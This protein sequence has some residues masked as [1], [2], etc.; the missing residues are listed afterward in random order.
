[1]R[2][3]AGWSVADETEVTGAEQEDEN[4]LLLARAFEVQ[5]KKCNFF[6][7]EVFFSCPS[8]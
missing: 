3:S 8:L 7:G 2:I 1:V 5:E 6:H 4:E